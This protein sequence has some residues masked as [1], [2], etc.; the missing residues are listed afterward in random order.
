MSWLTYLCNLPNGPVQLG[1][2]ILIPSALFQLL[3]CYVQ[4]VS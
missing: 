3:K 1:V 2:V 4:Y